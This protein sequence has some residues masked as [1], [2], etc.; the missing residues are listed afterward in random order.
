MKNWPPL[1]SKS[2]AKWAILEPQLSQKK[3]K[4]PYLD[5]RAFA[6]S[7]RINRAHFA[8]S[9]QAG[10]GGTPPSWTPQWF[11]QTVGFV[12]FGCHLLSQAK[13]NQIGQDEA[14]YKCG[15]LLIEDHALKLVLAQ[16]GSAIVSPLQ[17]MMVSTHQCAKKTFVLVNAF[18]R[19]CTPKLITLTLH[20]AV[21]ALRRY[22]LSIFFR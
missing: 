14:L 21:S 12:G 1:K 20:R 6:V 7:K 16:C 9:C 10:P 15:L 3:T 17:R 22:N 19:E 4:N 8:T 18:H 2:L 5:K 13:G 11:Y